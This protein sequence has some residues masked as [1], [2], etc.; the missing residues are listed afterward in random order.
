MLSNIK[1]FILEQTGAT[2]ILEC[3]VVQ[4]VWSGF[5]Q[6]LRVKLKGAPFHESVVVKNIVLSNEINQPKGWNTDVSRRRKL[7]SYKVEHAWYENYAGRCLENCRVPIF[8]GGLIN[9]GNQVLLLEDLNANGYPIRKN[10]LSKKEVKVCLSWLASFHAEFM[11]EKTD[12]LWKKG[13]Y[14]HL[15]TRKD[16]HASMPSSELKVKAAIIDQKLNSCFFKTLVHGDSKV[17]NFCFSEDGTKVSAV[18][19]QYVGEGCGMKDVAYLFSS[20]MDTKECSL[21]ASSLID[22]YFECLFEALSGKITDQAFVLLELEWRQMYPLAWVDFCRFLEGWSPNHYK[23]N[24]YSRNIV[25]NSLAA[26]S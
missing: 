14:W 9:E 1:S 12:D 26:I 25:K 8:Y 3:E 23:V 5:G 19:F 13:T 11:H 21:W 22:Y 4:E 20:C 7:I 16:E 6:V 18:D 24:D 2:D 10:H 15:S 17:A